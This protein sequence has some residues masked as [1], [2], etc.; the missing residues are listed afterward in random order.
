MK[1]KILSILSVFSGVLVCLFAIAMVYINI[2]EDGI[3]ARDTLIGCGLLLLGIIPI[4]FG[5]MRL[6][7]KVRTNKIIS[8]LEQY[9]S[10][11]G[12]EIDVI[13]I[14]LG[15]TNEKTTKLIQELIFY[16]YVKRIYIDY[17]KKKVIYLDSANVQ[18]EENVN[19]IHVRCNNC[20][21]TSSVLKGSAYQCE[22]CGASSV[23]QGVADKVVLI[24]GDNYSAAETQSLKENLRLGCLLPLSIPLVFLFLVSLFYLVTSDAALFN[25]LGSFILVGLPLGIFTLLFGIK[26]YNSLKEKYTRPLV[27]KYLSMIIGTRKPEGVFVKDLAAQLGEDPKMSEK[28]IKFLIKRKYLAGVTV[29]G[30][31][32]KVFFL[33]D[34]TD[35]SRFS[36][37]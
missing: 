33:D 14:N 25:R 23:A 21:G 37:V 12:V 13:S 7:F 28:N 35:Y 10:P 19:F 26:V 27:A 8:L 3:F 4:Y 6:T 2:I 9:Q 31:P 15:I 29:K 17:I 5:F 30:A 11:Y 32:P 22:Y 20:G 1:G 18:G 24:A 34:G 36:P 16:G